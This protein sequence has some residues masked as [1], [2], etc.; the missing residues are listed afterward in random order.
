MDR[1][2]K[3]DESALGGGWGSAANLS[4]SLQP[5]RFGDRRVSEVPGA[6]GPYFRLGPETGSGVVRAEGHRGNYARVAADVP[7]PSGLSGTTTLQRL[8]HWPDVMA[9]PLLP[10]PPPIP[11]PSGNQRPVEARV[12]GSI[13]AFPLPM[14]LQNPATSGDQGQVEAM[15]LGNEGSA[16]ITPAVASGASAAGGV[17]KQHGTLPPPIPPTGYLNEWRAFASWCRNHDM[18]YWPAS[19]EAVTRHLKDQAE[20]CKYTKIA[21]I[22]GAIS[23]TH[24]A[25]K[26]EDPCASDIVKQTLRELDRSLQGRRVSSRDCLGADDLEPIR[27]TALRPRRRG[28]SDRWESPETARKRGLVDIALCSLVVQ[29]GLRCEEAAAL[30]WE[31][32]T[33][34][35]GCQALIRIRDRWGGEGDRA[36]A[37]PEQTRR[38]LQAIPKDGGTAGSIFGLSAKR[39]R[40]RIDA[41][42]K[43]A[44]IGKR[45]T[46]DPQSLPGDD[47]AREMSAS[48]KC[49]WQAFR[50][51]CD[52][53][54]LRHL[55][56]DAGTV[57][58]FIRHRADQV[59][60][61][62]VRQTYAVISQVHRR[63][64]LVNPC[65]F[66]RVKAALRAVRA[67]QPSFKP[68]M[69]D[70]DAMTAI[71]TSALRPRLSAGTWE[72]VDA[73]R[74]RG[75]V[76]IALCSVFHSANLSMRQLLELE[77]RD[78]EQQRED[79]AIL[80]VRSGLGPDASMD[81]LVLTGQIVRDLEA[82]RG[83]AGPE[84]A[85]F[86]LTRDC[87]Y[88]RVD[89]AAT[90]AGF[91]A[92]HIGVPPRTLACTEGS[93]MDRIEKT[94]ESAFGGGWG[95]AANLTH[96]LQPG[97][98]GD[99]RVS[100]VPGAPGPCFRLGPETGSGV[101]CAEGH[102]GNY[103]RVAADVSSPSGLS[104]TT[105]LQRL[106]HWPDVM[107]PPLLP[108][109]PPIPIPSGNQRPVE[110][111]VSGS[112]GAFP[113]PMLLQNPATSG[114]QWQVEPMVLGN[115]G[116]AANTPAVAFGASAA[117]GVWK[118]H[119]A[120]P[121][122]IPLTR[123]LSEWSA[124]ARWCRSHDMQYWPA[125]AQAVAHHLKDRA[126]SCESANLK[127]IRAAISATH[128]AARL[129]DP[130]AS[131]IVKQT[132][133]ELARRLPGGRAASGPF[134]SSDWLG[135]D[136][137]VPIREVA[138]RRRRLGL[139]DR[140]ERPE[141]ARKRGLVDIALC[142]LVVQAGL[143]CEE[144]A[145]LKWE[146]LTASDGRQA[147]IRVR[148]QR[149]GEGERAVA[150]PEQTYRDLQAIAKD[151][152]PAGS[153]FGLS[154]RWIRNRIDAA[155]NAAGLD[156]SYPG[157]PPRTIT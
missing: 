61:S 10:T 121:P 24:L 16:A 117:G 145:A 73:A 127:R 4:H 5:G 21:R 39:I 59:A 93:I 126:E 60:L 51:W 9:R 125:S 19:A 40:N 105:T 82:I 62:S 44:E 120:L 115:E 31:D 101:V 114:D 149:G 74:Q 133:R 48:Y 53:Q 100:E 68:T 85:M 26:L 106:R 8:Q 132:L 32:L 118:Q 69:L 90:A 146:D 66:E 96:S 46:R 28:R 111:R 6:P 52:Q 104:G 107:A 25:A 42:A 70:A 43:A 152:E 36:V 128:L 64:G 17:R 103:S 27:E 71:R 86:D 84:D 38:D 13:G 102:R 77:W 65:D 113:P 108:M 15:V 109:P 76:D 79:A 56:A 123:H 45:V 142:S 88:K 131:D 151:G 129:E 18:Q 155:A 50:R 134:S 135:A 157:V 83:G 63:A 139:S 153:I 91:D 34:S 37:I 72:S 12:S 119:G 20:S 92:S 81:M 78:L 141:T 140:W 35:D 29:A 143:R 30:K 58:D 57:A 124:F 14:L 41:A 137:L 23:A 138:F 33:E 22:R 54:G 94:D 55:P 80:T 95:A 156:A 116:S 147:A 2:E 75:L 97:R 11:I 7:S 136:D 122:P 98:F 1:I 89:A 144:A 150:I 67:A 112:I 130:C 47:S 110:A 49:Q 154:A 3:T 99:R 87:V 148:D